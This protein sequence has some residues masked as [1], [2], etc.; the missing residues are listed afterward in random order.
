LV[1][2]LLLPTG[3]NPSE[4]FMFFPMARS[5]RAGS[6]LLCA[7]AIGL[8]TCGSLPAQVVVDDIANPSAAKKGADNGLPEI[9]EIPDGST[10]ELLAFIDK[11]HKTNFKPTSRQQAEAF[12]RKVAVT[13][14]TVAD[15]ILA[16]AKPEDEARLRA[17][18]MKLQS[19]MLLTQM[20]DR[21]AE[22]AVAEFAK[23]LAAG[24]DAE[25]AAEGERMLLVGDAK[26]A[27]QTQDLEAAEA[28]VPGSG[29]SLR[30][31]RMTRSL[32]SWRCSSP[33]PSSIC[34]GAPRWPGRPTPPSA[35][36]LRRAATR[37]SRRWGRDSPACSAASR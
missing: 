23:E 15:K 13:S 30:T 36:R 11:L 25:L 20:G 10:E 3:A 21:E 29:R 28:L 12:L 33:A 19:L 5:C 22:A 6:V 26:K 1:D 32:P 4:V 8:L 31:P 2:P 17:S 35:R 37:R 27:L 34:R 16:Q 9:D 14:V 7:A 18:R 24:G